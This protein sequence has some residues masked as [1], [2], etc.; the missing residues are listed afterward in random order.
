[1][2]CEV[3]G[4]TYESTK[5]MQD[6]ALHIRASTAARE[7]FFID[8]CDKLRLQISRDKRLALMLTGGFR[9]LSGMHDALRSGAVD[10]IGMA[11]PFAAAPRA[12]GALLVQSTALVYGKP[13]S[14][15]RPAQEP[16]FAA[17]DLSM[18]L[19]GFEAAA[20]NIWHQ[21]QMKRL[22]NG[23]EPDL[24]LPVLRE[25]LLNSN[26]YIWEPRNSSVR[27][28][29]LVLTLSAAAVSVPALIAYRMLAGLG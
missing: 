8:Y 26:A 18:P 6:P 1:M 17:Y 22:A 14:V 4:G 25:V 10:L 16:A 13:D 2:P 3:S 20:Q 23:L 5:M 19:P 29:L 15:A 27:G 28:W 11:R 12:V 9:S 24:A 21:A 7:A